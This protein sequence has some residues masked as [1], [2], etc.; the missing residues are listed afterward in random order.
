[1]NSYLTEYEKYSPFNSGRRTHTVDR[2][3]P[4]CVVGQCT[5]EALGEWFSTPKV[6]ASANYGIDKNGVVGMFVR[7]DCRSWC[8]SNRANDQRAITIEC[9]SDTYKPYAMNKSVWDSLVSL[10]VDICRRYKKTKLVW[11]SDKNKAIAYEPKKDE[12]QLTVHR[13]FAATECPGDWLFKRLPEL[14]ELV[15]NRLNHDGTTVKVP[16]MVKINNPR[17]IYK[18]ETG[19]Q[20]CGRIG[21]GIY[22][23]IDEKTDYLDRPLGKLKSGAGWIDL[24]NV[25]YFPRNDTNYYNGL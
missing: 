5:I 18:T 11:I 19:M 15:T 21:E 1:M 24:T 14:A 13:F 17:E 23:I 6:E 20:I 12:M 10:C 4:H 25:E 2:I 22:T 16:F 9:A 7:E 8:S 3:T